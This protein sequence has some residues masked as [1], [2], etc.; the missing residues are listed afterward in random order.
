MCVMLQSGYHGNQGQTLKSWIKQFLE[1][2]NVTV[3]F[4]VQRGT[5]LQF[6]QQNVENRFCLTETWD[7]RCSVLDV[8]PPISLSACCFVVMS[9]DW[10]K[11][12][13]HQRDTLSVWYY[14]LTHYVYMF[15]AFSPMDT[16]VSSGY[17]GF[18]FSPSPYP[19]DIVDFKQIQPEVSMAQN[20]SNWFISGHKSRGNK[21]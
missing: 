17:F 20:W 13:L 11:G 21:V 16:V 15:S 5:L 1:P 12:M 6:M 4:K 7:Y 19:L 14:I 9:S 2:F 8:T 10:Y 3:V 18:R